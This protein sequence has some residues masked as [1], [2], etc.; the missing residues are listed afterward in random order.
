[1]RHATCD[2]A[3]G[4]LFSNDIQF[5]LQTQPFITGLLLQAFQSL[6]SHVHR[7][8]HPRRV[9][10]ALQFADLILHELLLLLQF[11]QLLLERL[12]GLPG[13]V[14]NRKEGQVRRRGRGGGWP[15]SLLKAPRQTAAEP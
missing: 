4:L 3:S 2:A 12:R 1:M 10:H 8:F 13:G 6:L 11:L 14:P 9:S 15:Q 5:L 7:P